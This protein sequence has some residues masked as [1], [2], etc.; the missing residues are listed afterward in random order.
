MVR[1]YL[2]SGRAGECHAF[3]N[4]H[5]GRYSFCGVFYDCVVG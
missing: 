4:D 5:V 2:Q 1:A 3:A